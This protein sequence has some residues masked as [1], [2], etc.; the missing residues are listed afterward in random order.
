MG[1]EGRVQ[2]RQKMG[3]LECEG[4]GDWEHVAFGCTE[5]DARLHGFQASNQAVKCVSGETVLPA[6]GT[7]AKPFAQSHQPGYWALRLG[8]Q[9]SAWKSHQTTC[10]SCHCSGSDALNSSCLSP[11]AQLWKPQCQR[12]LRAILSNCPLCFW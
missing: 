2:G 9:F 5:T 10:L 3:G 4:P 6:P 8:L 11:S 12:I 7:E 1:P